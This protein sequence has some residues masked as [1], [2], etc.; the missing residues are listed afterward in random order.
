MIRFA[1]LC[2]LLLLPLAAHAQSHAQSSIYGIVTDRTGAIVA[3][4]SIALQPADARW[5]RTATTD[6]TGAFRFFRLPSGDYSIT[7]RAVGFAPTTTRATLSG[8]DLRLDLVLEPAAIAEVVVVSS[9]HLAETPEDVARTPG[10]VEI[11]DAKTLE[12][13]RPFTFSDVLR[14]VAGVNVR[15]EE[16]FG[17]RPNIGIRG[18]N[19]TRSTKVLL[20]EDGIPFTYAPYGDNASYYHPP[21]DRFESLEVLKG[22]GQILY[23]PVTVGGVINYITPNPPTKPSG[24]LSLTGGN[25][26]YFNGH[27][28]FGGTWKNTGLLFDLMRKQ[29]EGARE[30][31]R[32]GLNDFNFKSVSTF[33]A[34]QA[35]TLKANYYGEDSMVT[36][37]G[38]REDEYR[39]NPRGNPFRNDHFDGHRAGASATHAYIFSPDLT[40]TT[41]L[42]GSY[43]RRHWWRQ[44]SN[45]AQR[46]NRLFN[47][48]TRTG[49]P[50]CLSMADLLTT[51]GNEGRLRRYYNF[52]IEPRFRANFSLADVRNEIDFG[53][54]AHFEDQDRLQV[55]GDT[56]TARS[57]ITVEDNLRRNQAYSG[58]VQNRFIFGAFAITPGLRLEHVRYLR[59]NRLANNGAGVTG[60]TSLTQLIPGLGLSFSPS[61]AITIFAGVHRGFAPPRTEDIINNSTGGVVDLDPELS[62]NYELGLRSAPKRGLRFDATFFRMDY[63]NQVVPASVAGGIGATLTNGGATLHQGVELTGRIDSAPFFDQTTNLYLRVAYTYLPA[64]RF[65]GVRFSSISGFTRVSVSGNRLPYAPEH[66]LDAA[67]GLSHPRGLDAMLEAT[68][69]GRQFSDDLNTVSPTPDGQRGLIPSYVV[70]NATVNY[71]LESWRTTFFVTTKNLFDRLYIVDRTRG[72]LPGSPRLIQAGLK[73]NF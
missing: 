28:N 43:F 7:A 73:W 34:R 38:L 13:A 64:A 60:R 66:T 37:S 1:L 57:G 25:R 67:I 59:T 32:S 29:G 50:D 51:C 8:A 52:G 22:S 45:S 41:S 35:L 5:R 63:E 65:T 48:T 69:I 42:Y 44:S 71:R 70:W 18:L 47:P 58:F 24:Y 39:A 62:W 15:D 49:D 33:G 31:T 10:S 56:P 17:L 11:I 40:L 23:G 54:R 55:N 2:S 19:P 9:T 72:I 3:G 68:Y 27:F 30:N 4:A 36:Y 6:E 21:V 20:L 12:S 61:T 46:P 26:D 14:R 16:G 53:L